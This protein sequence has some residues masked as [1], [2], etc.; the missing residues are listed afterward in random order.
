[1]GE[2]S[3]RRIGRQGQVWEE[4]GKRPR[5]MNGNL[6]LLGVKEVGRLEGGSL[7]SPRDLG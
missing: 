3:G 2:G 6:H 7:G 4:T 1:V 5:R